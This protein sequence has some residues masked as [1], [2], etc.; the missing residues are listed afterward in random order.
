MAP[1]GLAG[2]PTCALWGVHQ[3]PWLPPCLATCGTLPTLSPQLKFLRKFPNVPWGAKPLFLKAYVGA[4]VPGE[5]TSPARR[6]RPHGSRSACGTG[7]DRTAF[8]GRPV[9]PRVC[10]RDRRQQARAPKL[11]GSLSPSRREL[12]RRHRPGPRRPVPSSQPMA[13]AGQ[14]PDA[15]ASVQTPRGRLCRVAGGRRESPGSGGGRGLTR[16]PGHPGSSVVSSRPVRQ[17]DRYLQ[18]HRSERPAH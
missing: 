12:L 16:P 15:P 11:R 7:L 2:G 17:D 14:R 3:H 10:G 1:L 18:T 13:E 8:H 9:T 5:K 4:P 6:L